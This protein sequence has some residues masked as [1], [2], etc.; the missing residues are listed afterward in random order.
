MQ[1]KVAILKWILVILTDENMINLHCI[2]C[3]SGDPINSTAN[4]VSL[5]KS[6][7]FLSVDVVL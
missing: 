3:I 1:I 6:G 2:I 4:D 7:L 5:S